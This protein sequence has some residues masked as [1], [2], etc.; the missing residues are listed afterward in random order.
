MSDNKEDEFD[1]LASSLAKDLLDNPPNSKKSREL[2]RAEDSKPISEKDQLESYINTSAQKS[3]SILL[4]VIEQFAN[5]VGDDPDRANALA[6]LIKSNT[7]ML[8]LLN[9]RLIKRED[10]KTKVEIQKMKVDGNVI[11][12]VMSGGSGKS[13]VAS[14]QELFDELIK[15]AEEAE[16]VDDEKYNDE[17]DED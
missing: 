9:D 15:D 10:N 3:N 11:R 14:R 2:I 17:A 13:V 6:T 1:D 4:Q 12:D 7:D 16:F 8:K 5:D